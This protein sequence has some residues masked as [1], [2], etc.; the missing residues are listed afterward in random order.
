MFTC[1][2]YS[3]S[4]RTRHF[5]YLSLCSFWRARSAQAFS[6]VSHGMSALGL[7][8]LGVGNYSYSSHF[9]YWSWHSFLHFLVHLNKYIT[10]TIISLMSW[11]IYPLHSPSF[12]GEKLQHLIWYWVWHAAHTVRIQKTKGDS[13]FLNSGSPFPSHKASLPLWGSAFIP[14]RFLQRMG[15]Y[16]AKYSKYLPSY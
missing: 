14:F 7:K 16:I 3:E 6:I 9:S 1:F 5:I 11:G 10:N 13:T 2:S 4:L 12:A 15:I 8:A